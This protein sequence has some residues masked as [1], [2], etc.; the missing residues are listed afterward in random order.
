MIAYLVICMISASLGLI[1]GGVLASTKVNDLYERLAIA[2]RDL[3]E[4]TA[5]VQDLTS[6]ISDVLNVVDDRLSHSVGPDAVNTIRG[7][8]ARCDN[9]GL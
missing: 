9:I 1:I 2:E 5:V 6:A 7:A 4:Q 8:L 3:A